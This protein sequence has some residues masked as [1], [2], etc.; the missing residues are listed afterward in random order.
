MTFTPEQ[1]MHMSRTLRNRRRTRGFTLVELMI[2][3]LII[4]ILA[5]VGYPSYGQYVVRS[6]RKAAASALY[7]LADRQ[8]QF[9]LDNKSYAAGLTAL[10]YSDDVIGL[11]R[12]GQ[13][14]DADADDVIYTLTMT[15]PGSTTYQLEADP[16]GTQADRD[17][18]CGTLTLDD[19]GNRG[20]TGGGDNCW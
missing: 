9:F 5:A 16:E 19:T 20:A 11:D 17:G 10:G 14:T 13:F 3:L 15:D 12:D 8:E 18:G 7:R 4:S 1:A 6:N 2:V